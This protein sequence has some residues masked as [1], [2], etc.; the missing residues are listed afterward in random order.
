MY[1]IYYI[2]IL[3]TIIYIYYIYDVYYEYYI[4]YIH[5]RYTIYVLYVLYILHILYVEVGVVDLVAECK[6]SD[7]QQRP[8][9]LFSNHKR[10]HAMIENEVRIGMSYGKLLNCAFAT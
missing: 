6:G 8:V 5:Y 7:P 1:Y 10:K 3:Y 9:F 2:G 4:Y